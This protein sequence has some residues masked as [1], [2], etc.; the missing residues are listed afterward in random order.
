MKKSLGLLYN[1]AMPEWTGRTI[2]NVRIDKELARGGMGEVYVGTHLR[3]DRLVIVKVMHSYIEAD[4]ELQAR[5]ENEARVVAALRHPNIVQVFDFDIAEGHPYIV[6]EFLRG[7]SLAVYL[8]ELSNRNEKL[9]PA[10][11]ARLLSIMGTALDYAHEQGVIHRDIKPGN[12]I[13]HNRT[14]LFSSDL[15]L[16]PLTEPAITDFGLVRIHTTTQ[17]S[18]GKRSGTPAYMSPEQARGLTVDQRSDIYSLGIVLYEMVA[19]QVPFEAETNWGIILKHID[20]PPPP[21]PGIPPAVQAVIDRALAKDPDARYQ[22][23]RELAADY[24]DAVGL[25]SEANALRA[26][27]S[28]PITRPTEPVSAAQQRVPPARLSW[29]RAAVYSLTGLLFLA[30]ATWGFLRFSS[31]PI[32]GDAASGRL[33]FQDGTAPADQVTISTAS[34]AA[35]PQ[36]SQYEA[37]L[38]QDDGEQRISMGLLAF[39]GQTQGSLTFIDRE[40]RNLL[41]KYRMVEITREPEPDPSPNSSND[42]AFSASL[43]TDGLKHVRHLLV[44]FDATPGKIGFIRGLDADTHLLHGTAQQMLAAFKAGDEAALDQHAERM[45]NVIL[46]SQSEEYQDWNEDGTVDDPGDGYGLLLNGENLGYIQGTSTHAN[47]SL[48]SPDATQNMHTHGGHVKDCAANLDLW[49]AELR[50]QLRAI[51]NTSFD[52]PELEGMIREAVALADRIR[53]GI[54]VNG[55]E[56][57]EPI[58]GE[59]GAVT[60]YEHAYYMADMVILP[61][62]VQSQ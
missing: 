52:S 62:A 31:S 27:S 58:P 15:P 24:M 36:G 42:V 46:G 40:G 23:C 5:F 16:S 51:L 4:P 35:P 49:T 54:D 37:W 26:G 28:F 8:R 32:A 6:M 57:I 53:N 56:S 7:P 11:V 20:E 59:G 48:T 60:A 2:G 47:L 14:G 61:G 3:L 17:T 55:N 9:P 21:I 41:E 43:P 33:R 38:I 13:L 12:I 25:V 34:L 45:L 19:G 39:D 44:S 30:L 50:D 1:S 18:V 22:T 10:Q 29:K